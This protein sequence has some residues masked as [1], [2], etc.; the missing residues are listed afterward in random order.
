MEIEVKLCLPSK[1]TYDKLIKLLASKYI[2]EL[3]QRNLFFDGPNRELSRIKSTL[4]LRFYEG[5]EEESKCVLTH[6]GASV[7]GDGIS[8]VPETEH[9]ISSTDAQ[10]AMDDPSSL[11]QLQ[12]S[13]VIEKLRESHP[14]LTQLES[15]G[16]FENLRQEFQ[17]DKLHKLEI[18]WSKYAFGDLFEIECE[19][20][21]P[22]QIRSEL[23][24]F[25]Q[26]HEIPF[27][28]STMSKFARFVTQKME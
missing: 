8:R 7:I 15:L 4:R 24:S 9:E 6:K 2:R 26:E 5:Q 20:T 25:L 19:T 27:K 28:D 14:E 23:I 16:G 13:S 3:H 17:W 21:N 18:D 1:E 11:L 10:R 12:N 22:Q